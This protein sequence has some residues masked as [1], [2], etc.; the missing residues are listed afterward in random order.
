MR[1]HISWLSLICAVWMSSVVSAATAPELVVDIDINDEVW[2]RDQPMTPADVDSL[3]GNLHASGCQTLLIR[4]GCLGI[5][6]YRTQLGYPMSFDADHARKHPTPEIADVQQY[7]VQRSAWNDKYAKVIAD[8]NPP[9]AFIKAGHQ[10]G[11]KVIVW[12]DIFDDGYPGYRSKFLDENPQCQWTARDGKTHFHGVTSYAWPQSRAFRVAQAREL[13]AWGA[14]GIH[15]STSCHCR[16]MPN[17]HEEDFFGFEQPIVEAYQAK[18]GVDIR[19]ADDFDREAWHDLKG[20]AMVQLYRELAALCHAQEKE[21]WVGLQLGRHTQFAVDPHFS[22]NIAM[23]YT[24]H[25]RTLVDEGIADVFILGDYEAMSAPGQSYWSCK[26]DIVLKAEEDLY[27]WAAR[28]YQDHCA[29][30]T[31]LLLFSEWLPGDTQQL[32]DRMAFYADRVRTLGFDGID[33]H[34]AA[35]FEWPATKMDVLRRFATRLAEDQ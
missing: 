10:R 25:W 9:E 29:G 31:R 35:S 18:Y 2:L 17:T 23:R 34:E 32:E 4:A 7:I 6:P 5:L 11:M 15:C 21:F 3:V 19:T 26:K 14:D 1:S 27:G 8:F 13:L 16:H 24:N 28:T 22:T 30:K 12:L 20:D 33:V